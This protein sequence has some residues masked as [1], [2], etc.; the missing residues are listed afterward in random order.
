M[1]EYLV[2]AAAAIV[3][4]GLLAAQFL[5]QAVSYGPRSRRLLLLLGLPAAAAAGAV[6]AGA[7]LRPVWGRAAVAAATGVGVYLAVAAGAV[8]RWRNRKIAA[9]V[10]DAAALRRQIAHRQRVLDELYWQV[11]AAPAPPPPAAALPEVPALSEGECREAIAAYVAVDGPASPGRAAEVAG[12]RRE[13]LA[14]AAAD[15]R[16]RARLLEAVAADAPEESSRLALRA[17]LA[18]LVLAYRSKVRAGGAGRAAS[19]RSGRPGPEPWAAHGGGDGDGEQEAR[20]DL[21]RLQ[22]ELASVLKQR[23]ALR[24]RRLPLD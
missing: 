8:A 5:L 13:F 6:G 11:G 22:A 21:S 10:G 16:A 4:A 18:A 3:L 12:W 7:D 14:V 17:K 23:A 1:V 20:R 15:L 9:L 19:A 24:G 2:G